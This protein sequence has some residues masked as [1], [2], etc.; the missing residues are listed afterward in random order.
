MWVVVLL[1]ST[2]KHQHKCKGNVGKTALF[3]WLLIRLKKASPLNK[4]IPLSNYTCLKQHSCGQLKPHCTDVI[5]QKFKQFVLMINTLIQYKVLKL[6]NSTF[7][8]LK[9]KTSQ[10][11]PWNDQIISRP[12][13]S[14]PLNEKKDS[15]PLND[16]AFLGCKHT[17]ETWLTCWSAAKT[18]SL[19]ALNWS[20][21]NT[22]SS[23]TN[24]SAKSQAQGLQTGF[25][26][27]L[28]G[29]KLLKYS[30]SCTWATW[31]NINFNVNSQLSGAQFW[32]FSYN[33]SK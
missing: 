27:K 28:R 18:S 23:S 8:N 24:M 17:S 14:Q 26:W 11:R 10:S 21:I 6:K 3:I 19:F 1:N 2:D 30:K 9:M 33:I 5:F 29:I 13:D 32:P 20:A 15:Q 25:K 12:K 4:N 16:V 22:W 7:Q 31:A